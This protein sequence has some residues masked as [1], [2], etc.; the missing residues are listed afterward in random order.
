MEESLKPRTPKKWRKYQEVLE[1]LKA[2]M[3][4]NYRIRYDNVTDDYTQLY[5]I[6]FGKFK[7]VWQRSGGTG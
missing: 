7:K 4:C 2:W 3:K 1:G 6:G 5:A